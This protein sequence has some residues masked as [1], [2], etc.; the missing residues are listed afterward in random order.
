MERAIGLDLGARRVGVAIS[1]SGGQLA[2]PYE[3]IDRQRTDVVARVAEIVAEENAGV[4]VVG[5]PLSMSGDEGPAPRATRDEAA[6]LAAALPVP[7]E[8][9]DERLTTVSAHQSL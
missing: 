8:V 7:V 3:V 4:V 5:L 9:F 1:D 6:A 2:T